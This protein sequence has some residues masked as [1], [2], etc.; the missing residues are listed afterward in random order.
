MTKHIP[1]DIDD[2][3]FIIKIH[4]QRDSN[5][6]WTGDVTLGIIT[7]HDNPLSDNDYFYMMEF[8]NLICATVPMMSLD[9]EFRDEIQAF[10]DAEKEEEEAKR[11]ANNRKKKKVKTETTGNVIKVTFSGKVD[12]SA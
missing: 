2:E 3:D 4:P 10:V 12:G 1:L 5:N 11:V 8:S 6:K 7:S 9:P